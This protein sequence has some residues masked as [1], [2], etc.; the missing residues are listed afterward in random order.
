MTDTDKKII[1]LM[2]VKNEAWILNHTLDYLSSFCDYI[3]IGDQMSTDGSR[4]I[5]KNFQKVKVIDNTEKFH[6]NKIRWTLLDEAHKI[7][8][9]N[10]L[11]FLDADEYLDPE[12]FKTEIH[13]YSEGNI[14]EFPWINLWK[15]DDEYRCDGYWKELTK[16][17]VFIDDRKADYKRN[18]VL[19]DHTGRTPSSSENKIIKIEEPKIIHTEFLYWKKAQ[20]KQAWYRCNELIQNKKSARKINLKYR[21]SKDSRRVKTEK[22]ETQVSF[23][24]INYEVEKDWRYNEILNWFEEFGVEFFEKIDIWHI[25][26]LRNKFV[27]K[28]NREPKILT[29]PNFLI[30][31]NNIKNKLKK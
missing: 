5:Y 15:K 3:I 24:Q 29:Y 4:D 2:P 7:P 22:I 20:I 1:A 6:S 14:L 12:F 17:I 30:F 28:L 25:S 8:G 13:K 23:P 21:D 19:N 18:Y 16:Q 11:V 31:L 26:T 10:I 27:N 9:K